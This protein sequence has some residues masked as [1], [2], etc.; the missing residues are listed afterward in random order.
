MLKVP[1]ITGECI[2]ISVSYIKC[3]YLYA[4]NETDYVLTKEC[5]ESYKIYL[6]FNNVIWISTSHNVNIIIFEFKILIVYLKKKLYNHKALLLWE[7]SFK[8]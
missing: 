5:N 3:N 8:K 6:V 7:R 2:L 1:F 4:Y